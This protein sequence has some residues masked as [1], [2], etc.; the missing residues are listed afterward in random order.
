MA[1]SQ[2][3]PSR[4]SAV[5]RF[6]VMDIVGEVDSMKAL[7][8]NVISLGAGEP[9]GGAPAAVNREAARLHNR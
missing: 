8:M 4:R 2:F 1:A 5:P 3:S 7:G 6:Q 9:S